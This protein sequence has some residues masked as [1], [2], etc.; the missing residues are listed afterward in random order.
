MQEHV[1]HFVMGPY[2]YMHLLLRL[3]PR[4]FFRGIQLYYTW[5]LLTTTTIYA[6]WARF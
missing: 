5:V 6:T 3:G 2:E 4:C 1:Q